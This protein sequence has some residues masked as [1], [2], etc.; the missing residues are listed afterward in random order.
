LVEA[1]KLRESEREAVIEEVRG[2][3]RVEGERIKRTIEKQ[4]EVVFL[5]KGVG[6]VRTAAIDLW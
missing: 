3:K 2:N 1:R 5:R 6:R 4:V